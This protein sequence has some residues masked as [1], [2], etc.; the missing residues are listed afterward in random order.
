MELS[1]L[2]VL[3]CLY[4]VRADLIRD[5]F[6]MSYIRVTPVRIAIPFTGNVPPTVMAKSLAGYAAVYTK[7]NFTLQPISSLGVG[8][9]LDNG[10]YTG[11]LGELM[12]NRSDIAL[13]GTV[14]SSFNFPGVAPGYALSSM[15]LKVH[16][17]MKPKLL[18]PA[19]VLTSIQ[20][21]PLE[22]KIY[23][24]VVVHIVAGSIFVATN[25]APSQYL[26]ASFQ[27]LRCFLRQGNW[28]V[29]LSARAILWLIFSLFVL[30]TVFGY[31]LNLMSTDVFVVKQSRRIETLEDVFD[32][33]FDEVRFTMT[34]NDLFFN[35]VHQSKKNTIMGQVYN[36]MAENSDCSRLSTCNFFEFDGNFGSSEQLEAFEIAKN[37]SEQGGGAMFLTDELMENFIIPSLCRIQPDMAKMIYTG[38]QVFAEDI[39]VNLMRT[40]IDEHV[41]SYL[42]YV[43]SSLFEFKLAWINAN[44][45]IHASLDTIN[46]GGRDLNYLYCISRKM[47]EKER[48][49]V[50]TGSAAYKRLTIISLSIL[51][52]AFFVLLAELIV[53]SNQ[54]KPG[55]RKTLMRARQVKHHELRRISRGMNSIQHSDRELYSRKVIHHR[56]A[57]IS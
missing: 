9:R 39:M 23:L 13:C 31:T 15:S 10:S 3:V 47:S 49:L 38:P 19:D 35:Y 29:E 54:V 40:D 17:Q 11:L 46:P 42:R 57:I 52:F 43:D 7:T 50:K 36:K 37:G 48:I 56:F 28:N 20:K 26:A 45:N 12:R 5:R 25:H 8:Y 53:S 32:P 1:L 51:I 6:R 30:V 33:Y 41:D 2:L 34:K 21:S 24:I 22:F 55:H 44:E 18:E 16:S 27:S 4:F 14:L